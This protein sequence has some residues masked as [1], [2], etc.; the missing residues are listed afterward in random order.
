MKKK[1]KLQRIEN[2][3]IN[4]YKVMMERGIKGCFVYAHN[5]GLRGYLRK[6]IY[7]GDYLQ[8]QQSEFSIAAESDGAKTY[9]KNVR[10][11]K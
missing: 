10:N 8:L 3:V 5:P 4:S 1:S 7:G 2:F 9:I 11:N 6:M